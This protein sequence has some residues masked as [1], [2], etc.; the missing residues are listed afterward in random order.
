MM[1]K[2]QVKGFAMRMEAARSYK[3]LI[4]N[5]NTTWNRNPEDLDLNMEF[6]WE[7]LWE[8]GHLQDQ[9]EDWRI[10]LK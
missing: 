9:G 1:V 10:V 2:I 7:N 8:S 3:T 5:C 4:S 6:W